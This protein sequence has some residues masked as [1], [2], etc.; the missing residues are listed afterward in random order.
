MLS[1]DGPQI[2]Q[3]RQNGSIDQKHGYSLGMPHHYGHN[4]S[5]RNQISTD[6]G[7]TYLNTSSSYRDHNTSSHNFLSGSNTPLNFNQNKNHQMYFTNSQYAN[8]Q[9]S[10]QSRPEE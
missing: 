9:R 8:E 1:N 2:Q 3:K 7:L 4:K 10:F 6:S 5:I